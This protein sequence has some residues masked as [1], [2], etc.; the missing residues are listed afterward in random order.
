MLRGSSRFRRAAE[1]L[2][3]YLSP[4]TRKSDESMR[5]WLQAYE[6]PSPE[7]TQRTNDSPAWSPGLSS[8]HSSRRPV[9]RSRRR[10]CEA[11]PRAS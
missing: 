1:A 10:M 11:R 3:S 5:F 2:G 6:R 9:P 4:S 8:L 7:I